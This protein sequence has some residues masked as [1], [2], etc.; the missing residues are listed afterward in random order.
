VKV[1]AG[2]IRP[3]GKVLQRRAFRGGLL[4]SSRE[5]NRGV[6]QVIEWRGSADLGPEEGIARLRQYGEFDVQRLAK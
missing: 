3:A 2:L 6:W 4:L 1:V 5:A